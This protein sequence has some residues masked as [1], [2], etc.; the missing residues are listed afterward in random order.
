MTL[1]STLGN[2]WVNWN[3]GTGR[4]GVLMQEN[5]AK[6]LFL[7]TMLVKER[8]RARERERERE[9]TV[10]WEHG[11]WRNSRGAPEVKSKK[12]GWERRCTGASLIGSRRFPLNPLPRLLDSSASDLN[13]STLACATETSTVTERKKEGR[14]REREREREKE[15][16]TSRRLLI[17]ASRPRTRVARIES[18]SHSIF[19]SSPS[20]L[21][22]F[23]P[24]LSWPPRSCLLYQPI[25]LPPAVY[26]ISLLFFLSSS[27]NASVFVP[28][29]RAAFLFRL[30][31]I[32]ILIS[33][34]CS[35]GL[36]AFVNAMQVETLLL[37][38]I[39]IAIR[40]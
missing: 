21:V 10:R 29:F 16:A 23:P 6:R 34:C 24:P 36:R 19:L 20:R 13:N 38:P 5:I 4:Y 26:P 15:S 2:S 35:L 9:N 22:A 31:F 17:D 33:I 25:S 18:E 30:S 3:G 28:R 37:F 11:F 8:A 27:R 12:K 14:E 40:Q 32:Y 39:I 7:F 1:E